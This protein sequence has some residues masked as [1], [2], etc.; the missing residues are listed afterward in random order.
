MYLCATAKQLN[1]INVPYRVVSISTATLRGNHDGMVDEE[2][3]SENIVKCKF[4]TTQ[5]RSSRFLK[6]PSSDEPFF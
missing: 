6:S 1:A 2:T 4:T 3:I 5:F